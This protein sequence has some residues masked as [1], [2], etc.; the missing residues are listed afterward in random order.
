M[1]VFRPLTDRLQWMAALRPSS[2]K[3]LANARVSELVAKE[4]RRSRKRLEE[5]V[6]RYPSASPRE[7]AQRLIDEKKG[8][9]G[10]L[11]GVSGVFG[12]AS[13]PADLLMMVWLELVLFVDIAGVY[14]ANLQSAR[15]R[16]ELLDLY[17]Y[18]TG[19]GPMARSGPKVVGKLAATLLAKGGLGT[20]GRAIPL[21]AAPVSAYLNSEHLQ[22]MG[23]EA[24]LFYEGFGKVGKRRKAS[25]TDDATA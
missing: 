23:E 3:R 17:G 19:I 14:K 2:L 6:R 22:R 5:L 16:S 25:G 24:I 4:T 15:A 1:S 7:L 18:A 12:L 9:A 20:L 11:G 13:L 21:V 8:L 10:M